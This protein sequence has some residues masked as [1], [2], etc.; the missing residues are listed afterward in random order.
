MQRHRRSCLLRVVPLLAATAF[1]S[2]CNP[3]S[4]PPTTQPSPKSPTISVE[5]AGTSF[6]LEIAADPESRDRGLGGRVTIPPDGGMIF[7]FPDPEM[8]SFV[9][10]D[11]PFP[12]DLLYLD[13]EGRVL[14][15]FVMLPEAPRTPEESIGS[16][17]DDAYQA[18]LKAY[19]SPA[20]AQFVIEVPAGTITNLKI[21]MGTRIHFDRERLLRGVR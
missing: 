10:S 16:D 5:I 21:G 3:T 7:V 11:C 15:T 18:R 13:S 14:A 17:G 19:M 1:T 8:L 4:T 12:I 20:P 6:N 2:A 9:M